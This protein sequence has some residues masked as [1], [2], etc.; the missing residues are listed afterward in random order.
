MPTRLRS[1]RLLRPGSLTPDQIS[2][3]RTLCP[4]D[5][6]G[7][8]QYPYQDAES[9]GEGLLELQ[10][11]WNPDPALQALQD[12]LRAYLEDLRARLPRSGY[13]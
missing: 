4:P 12:D 5:A 10:L 3:L 9:V 11:R 2:D 1:C 6:P 7:Y 13:I 8:P